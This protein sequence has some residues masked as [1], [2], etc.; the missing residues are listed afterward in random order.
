MI[1]CLYNL[2]ANLDRLFG[3]WFFYVFFR[4]LDPRHTL[5][6]VG[7]AVFYTFMGLGLINVLCHNLILPL[8]L[9]RGYKLDSRKFHN[10]AILV[11][12]FLVILFNELFLVKFTFKMYLDMLYA[13]FVQ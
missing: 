2:S 8:L 5:N 13:V 4:C 7:E 3:L 10:Q 12:L 6:K 9:P 1:T 11:G